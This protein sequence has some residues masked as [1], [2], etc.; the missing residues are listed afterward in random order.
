MSAALLRA[1]A[2][3]LLAARGPEE[4][5]AT[6]FQRLMSGEASHP[7]LWQVLGAEPQQCTAALETLQRLIG[8]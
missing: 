3:H 8:R 5:D 7:Q 6:W 1:K 4:A 2:P